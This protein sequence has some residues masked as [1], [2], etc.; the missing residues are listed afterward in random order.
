LV[1]RYR[2]SWLSSGLVLVL[3]FLLSWPLSAAG[4]EVETDR[5]GK[6]AEPPPT[7]S[8]YRINL[9]DDIPILAISGAVIAVGYIFQDDFIR[10]HCP[11]DPS[12]VN[13]FDRHV[14]GFRSDF[15]DYLSHFTLALTLVAPPALDLWALGLS[16]AWAE[17]LTVYV[18]AL[19]ANAALVTITKYLA[20]RAS[21]R[22]YAGIDV[23][24]TRPS[25]FLNFYSAHA[26][27]AFSAL[28]TTAV[29]IQKRYGTLWPWPVLA[30]L[31]VGSSIAMERIWAGRH[32]Y[33]DII[34]GSVVGAGVGALVPMLH[35]RR[36]STEPSV[37]LLPT[38]GGLSLVGTF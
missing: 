20:Q 14:I 31:V 11:C 38:P 16:Q 5:E 35:F 2:D 24:Q 17:D 28:G 8:I 25:D 26:A 23:D 27:F 7:E 36:S 12:E 32:F 9:S 29:T 34:V 10:I 18:E 19:A 15:A 30:M 37:G 22:L 13:A 4:Q 33:T 3:I 1:P 21:P 6:P